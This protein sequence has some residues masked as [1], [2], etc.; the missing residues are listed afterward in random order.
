MAPAVTG[1]SGELAS[2]E[3]GLGVRGDVNVSA[4]TDGDA[5]GAVHGLRSGAAEKCREDELAAGGINL[6][7]DY[8]VALAAGQ[9][10]WLADS[11]RLPENRR[12]W[13]CR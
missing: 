8:V 6:G 10:R 2:S 4:G 7:N 5:A 9:R 11:R 13:L 3:V 12:P 1:R